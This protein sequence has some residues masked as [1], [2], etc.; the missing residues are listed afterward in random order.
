MTPTEEPAGKYQVGEGEQRE[1][2]SVVFGKT[3]IA[4]LAMF[5]QPLHDMEAMLNLRAHTGLCVLQF[6]LRA[7]QWILLKC[8]AQARPHCRVPVDCFVRILRTLGHAW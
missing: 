7:T 5:K 6:F 3:A 8:L 1:Q 4:C 2:L